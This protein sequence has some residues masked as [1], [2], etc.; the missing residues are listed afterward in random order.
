M[1]CYDKP[2]RGGSLVDFDKLIFPK[3]RSGDRK[4]LMPLRGYVIGILFSTK[5]LPLRGFI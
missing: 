2:C 1:S 3:S 5:V 4:K